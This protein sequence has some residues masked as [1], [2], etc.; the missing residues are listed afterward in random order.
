MSLFKPNMAKNRVV[1]EF[2]KKLS[3]IQMGLFDILSSLNMP[4]G[5]DKKEYSAFCAQTVN[6]LT[7]EGL[8]EPGDKV[9]PDMKV[10]IK[11]IQPMI[12]EQSRQM[13]VGANKE[14]KQIIVYTLRMRFIVNQMLHGV[15][16]HKTVEGKNI[17]GLLHQ[18][19][20]EFPEQ[21]SAKMFDE[22]AARVL[23]QINS[24]KA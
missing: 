9:P 4:P 13:M 7:G 11:R 19:G 15:E 5:M 23:S 17:D 16:W 6:Y 8:T 20:A 24:L 18:Y 21:I 2:P 3:F 10:I 22:V 14:F 12:P 1:V